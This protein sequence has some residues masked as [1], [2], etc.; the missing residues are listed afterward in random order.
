MRNLALRFMKVAAIYGVIGFAA[1]VYMG[2]TG[3]F[4]LSSAHAHITLL[5][6]LSFGV[7]AVVYHLNPEAAASKLAEI[8]FWLSNIGLVIMTTA[9]AI[10]HSGNNSAETAAG[11]GSIIML[12]S[13]ILFSVIVFTRSSS[14]ISH[15]TRKGC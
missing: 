13:F 3:S 15:E 8:H 10:I 5:G 12:V 6:W 2:M 1:G 9:V 14:C 7:F 11:I 4:E